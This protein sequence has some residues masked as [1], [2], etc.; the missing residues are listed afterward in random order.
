MAD[1]ISNALDRVGSGMRTTAAEVTYY[2][3]AGYS[4]NEVAAMTGL[5]A[6]Q[7]TTLRQEVASN[8]VTVLRADGFSDGEIARSLG[9]PT[10]AIAE[11]YSGDG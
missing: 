1:L 8:V 2:T 11:R 9:V 5:R 7:V 10:T 3:A 4:T 6:G